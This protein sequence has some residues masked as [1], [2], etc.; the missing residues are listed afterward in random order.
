MVIICIAY[1][2]AILIVGV[3]TGFNV[4]KVSSLESLSCGTSIILGTMLILIA[5]LIWKQKE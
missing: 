5:L 3:L 1:G 2:L 4:L